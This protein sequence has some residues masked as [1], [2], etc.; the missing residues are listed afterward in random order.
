[1]GQTLSQ[2]VAFS[3]TIKGSAIDS[4]GPVP[5][6]SRL[7]YAQIP[8]N[9][10]LSDAVCVTPPLWN[11]SRGAE[12]ARGS[13]ILATFNLFYPPNSRAPDCASG[14]AIVRTL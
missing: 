9:T 4:A 12:W 5:Q 2:T 8:Q 1:M 14:N 13:Y 11:G 10:P 6:N 3:E 7:Q